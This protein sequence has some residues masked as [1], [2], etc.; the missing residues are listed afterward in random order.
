MTK[1]F[2]N[3]VERFE[4]NADIASVIAVGESNKTNF[5]DIVSYLAPQHQEGKSDSAFKKEIERLCKKMVEETYDPEDAT[6][7]VKVSSTGKATQYYWSDE[8]DK[9]I[10][11]EKFIITTPRALALQFS[12][13]HL[14]TLL[15]SSLLGGLEEDFRLAEEKLNTEGVKLSDIIDYSPTGLAM[16]HRE[17]DEGLH[18]VINIVFDALVNRRVIKFKYESIHAKFEGMNVVSPQK[19]LYLSGQTR[20]LG[21]E[22]TKDALKYFSID[23]MMDVAYEN[24]KHFREL[25]KSE[26][27]TTHELIIKCHSWVKDLLIRSSFSEAVNCHEVAKDVWKVKDQVTIPKHFNDGRPDVF[28]IANYLSSFGDSLKVIEPIFLV[29]EMRRRAEKMKELY[30]GEGLSDESILSKSPEEMAFKNNRNED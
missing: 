2:R 5:P 30:S 19:L 29:N 14:S 11:I 26:F 28:Y 22:H 3:S 15:P 18:K 4:I 6:G 12:K 20:L 8:V 23:K 7:L 10:Y 16:S 24:D 25:D 1:V 9:S 27:E 13:K 21:Y 17:F